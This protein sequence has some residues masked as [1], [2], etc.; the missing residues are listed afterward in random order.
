MTRYNSIGRI[1][2][3]LE[4]QSITQGNHIRRNRP[5]WTDLFSPGNPCGFC[6][7]HKD[8]SSMDSF[9]SL[10]NYF[11]PVRAIRIVR[12]IGKGDR[13]ALASPLNTRKVKVSF[14]C[15]DSTMNRTQRHY[16]LCIADG[17][18]Y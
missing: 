16:A 8:C 3:A 11:E 9:L 15:K 17:E 10:S 18:T 5:D 6:L 4:S 14:G 12:H 13:R 1:L 2:Q 7:R